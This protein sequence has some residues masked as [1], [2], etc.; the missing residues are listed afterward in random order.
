MHTCMI[1]ENTHIDHQQPFVTRFYSSSCGCIL[2]WVATQS[3]K[4]FH[5]LSEKKRRK[6]KQDNGRRRTRRRR[7]TEPHSELSSHYHNGKYRAC[8][9][10]TRR[11]KH[12]FRVCRRQARVPKKHSTWNRCTQSIHT[13]TNNTHL[14]TYTICKKRNKNKTNKQTHPCTPKQDTQHSTH[15]SRPTHSKARHNSVTPCVMY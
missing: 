10:P 15:P 12:C 14:H 4:H 8:C 2:V 13:H 1:A 9:S 7:R 3:V 6:K 5:S 11:G